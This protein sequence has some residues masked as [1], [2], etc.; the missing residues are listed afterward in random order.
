MWGSGAGEVQHTTDLDNGQSFGSDGHGFRDLTDLS[1][2]D[3]G[4]GGGE[5]KVEKTRP[6]PM[7]YDPTNSVACYSSFESHASASTIIT[8][9]SN[10]IHKL[11]AS[12]FSVEDDIFK[13]K[14][15]VLSEVGPVV[16]TAQVFAVQG[17]SQTTNVVEFR[18]RQGD[19]LHY[20]NLFNEIRDSVSDIVAS[21]PS[22][23][24]PSTTDSL[25]SS[26]SSLVS[27]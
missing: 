13:L 25:S 19:S 10:V 23:S 16:F 11:S 5:T 22:S 20:F 18:R 6:S 3:L 26:F 2:G 1:G 21:K 24:T 17:A 14:A 12:G 7:V 4:F 15:K 27:V 8:R 9:L